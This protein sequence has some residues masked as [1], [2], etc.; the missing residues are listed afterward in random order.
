MRSSILALVVAVSS[1]SVAAQNTSETL[2]LGAQCSEDSQC[3]GGAHCYGTT[4][5]T[6]KTCGSFNAQCSR[7]DQCATNTCDNGI[8]SGFLATSLYRITSASA[9][10]SS[11]VAS[12]S[13]AP[14]T[15]SAAAAASGSL[16]LGVECSS[17][18]QCAAGAQCYGTTAGTI[19]TCGSF[20]AECQ[21]DSQCATNT[22]VSGICSG[23][24]A[25]SLYI[26]S[27]AAATSA[28]APVTA[29]GALPAPFST[30]VA[31][32]GSLSLGAECSTTEQCAGGAQ[33]F[34]ST[35]GQIKSCG[36]FNAACTSDSQCA[37]NSCNN[38]LCNGFL[39]SSLWKA[40]AA[41]TSSAVGTLVSSAA[42]NSANGTAVVATG[43]PTGTMGA[44]TGGAIKN[45]A[46]TGAAVVAAA[47]AF[48]L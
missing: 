42:I 36:K 2:G 19:K 18:D 47:L 45:G 44:Y 17:S 37:T 15:T 11:S 29:G 22:C 12:A 5:G 26:I 34:A 24:L 38:G 20:N 6:I 27:S 35:A 13:S 40:P 14:A 43:S 9:T 32:A 41:S 4:S 7:D 48:A 30:V 31:A 10:A 21:G 33:C 28:S 23:F 3:A 16:G 1:V 8:C 46:T 25:S 39:A